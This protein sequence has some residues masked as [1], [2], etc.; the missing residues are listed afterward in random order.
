VWLAVHLDGSPA[1]VGL[2][3]GG[4]G[5]VVRQRLLTDPGEVDACRTEAACGPA[6]WQ[7]REPPVEPGE[8]VTG[9]L[10][11][12]GGPLQVS[13]GTSAL[14]DDLRWALGRFTLAG[15]A[16]PRVTAVRFDPYDPLCVRDDGRTTFAADG[17]RVLVCAE[18]GVPCR[19]FGCDAG[20]DRRLLLL[21]ELG[22]AWVDD[23]VPAATRA[24]FT[25]L[26]DVGRWSD[27][28]PRRL[29]VEWAADTLAWGLDGDPDAPLRVGPAAC[30]T[31]AAGFRLLTDASPL[32][33]CP[34]G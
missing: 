21:H 11:L 6:W 2:T 4:D 1:L 23:N 32:T 15:L 3:L 5:A 26:V 33:V 27:G 24:Q 13:N 9:W 8:R 10:S 14:V 31:L 29:G 17:A 16:A 28:D 7:G 25:D 12:A 18:E 30:P 20:A 22:H 19:R 34:P